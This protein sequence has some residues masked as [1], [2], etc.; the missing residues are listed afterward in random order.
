M[1]RRRQC[2]SQA[3]G[4]QEAL[5][6]SPSPRGRPLKSELGAHSSRGPP[7]SALTV[8]SAALC[9]SPEP[10]LHPLPKCQQPLSSPL[11]LAFQQL[12]SWHLPLLCPRPPGCP[13]FPRFTSQRMRFSRGRSISSQLQGRLPPC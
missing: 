1:T 7:A 3:E 4:F 5:P 9:K 2:P 10:T 12:P 6:I 11:P 13:Q 8:R